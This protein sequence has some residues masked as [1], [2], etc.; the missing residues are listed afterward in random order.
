MHAIASSPRPI[1]RTAARVLFAKNWYA[2]DKKIVNEDQDHPFRCTDP[3]PGSKD[4]TGQ[5][6]GDLV[7]VGY[8]RKG[9]GQ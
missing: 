6:K 2:P 7:V 8:W 3:L 1:D 9:G 4:R 5:R